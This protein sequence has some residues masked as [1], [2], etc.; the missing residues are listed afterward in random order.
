MSAQ[1][2]YESPGTEKCVHGR[3]PRGRWTKDS[4]EKS[5]LFWQIYILGF[6]PLST[7]G[8]FAYVYLRDA[9]VVDLGAAGPYIYCLFGL[10][11][12]GTPLVFKRRN[13]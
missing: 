13:G 7:A 10:L 6:L 9:G 8:M 5:R 12:L 4:D 3:P 1:N 11:Y 2:P